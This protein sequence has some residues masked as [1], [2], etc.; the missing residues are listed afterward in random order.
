MNI[1]EIR[2][3]APIGATHYEICGKIDKYALYWKFNDN[4][5][6]MWEHHR[7]KWTKFKFMSRDYINKTKPL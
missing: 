6:F 7:D 4:G 5:M 1:D 3:N 2:K